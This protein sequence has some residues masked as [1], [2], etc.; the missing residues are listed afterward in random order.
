MV[1]VLNKTLLED[2]IKTTTSSTTTTTITTTTT[3]TTA[4]SIVTSN[5]SDTTK[6]NIESFIEL[7]KLKTLSTVNNNQTESLS[8]YSS[9]TLSNS[10]GSASTAS[11]T[12][13]SQA[14]VLNNCLYCLQASETNFEKKAN[15]LANTIIV[16][17]HLCTNPNH[18]INQSVSN[19]INSMAF[20]STLRAKKVLTLSN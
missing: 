13:L 6:R 16:T 3:T 1:N 4:A 20:K 15:Q 10:S 11:S 5:S 17:P 12:T 18:L 2:K 19:T 9:S 14:I 8:V 7:K